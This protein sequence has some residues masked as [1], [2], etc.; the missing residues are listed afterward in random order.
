MNTFIANIYINKYPPKFN[1]EVVQIRKQSQTLSFKRI[2]DR[3]T[4]FKTFFSNL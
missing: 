1:K 3:K 2:T 4:E